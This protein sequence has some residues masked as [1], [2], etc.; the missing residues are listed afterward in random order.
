[1]AFYEAGSMCSVGGICITPC[2]QHGMFWP[3]CYRR[4]ISLIAPYISA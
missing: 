3:C 1:M 2:M 4:E